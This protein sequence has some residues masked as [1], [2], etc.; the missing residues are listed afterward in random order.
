MISDESYAVYKKCPKNIITHL[1]QVN[2]F[3]W[4]HQNIKNY[5]S[6]RTNISNF[7]I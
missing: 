6:R 1:S 7:L 5:F 3:Y 4:T 2:N